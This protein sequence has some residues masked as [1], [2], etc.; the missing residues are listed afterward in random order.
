M[1]VRSQGTSPAPATAKPAGRLLY[2]D[3]IRIFLTILVILHHLMVIYAG[4]GGWIYLEGRED[5]FTRL[6]GSWFCGS[7]QA[8]FMGLFLL[9]SAYFVPGS[10][11]RKGPGKFLVDRLVRLGI[12]L[13]F[14]S[15]VLRPLLIYLGLRDE[16]GVSFWA[17]YTHGYFRDYGLI[18][19]GP[20]WFIETLLIFSALYVVWR[21]V[22]R[23]A[24]PA[25]AA[26]SRFPRSRTIALFALLL[27]LASFLVRLQFP[28]NSRFAP[29]NL[30][31]ANLPQ[32]IAL[33]ILGLLAYRRRWLSTLSDATGKLWLGIG[34]L[35][36]A[37]NGPVQLL[38]G[39]AAPTAPAPAGEVLMSLV[40]AEWEAFVCVGMC[41][42]LV[43]FFRRHL[44]RQG[45]LARELSRT[46]YTA[47]L[48]HEPVVTFAALFAAGVMIYPLLK[49]LL[50][51]L[52]LV[53]VCFALSSLI[54]RIPYADRVL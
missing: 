1:G 6:I 52:V 30:Q 17:W 13:A 8:Y 15:W 50:A 3:N 42:G 45:P 21:L 54:R 25:P 53:P 4:S 38:M 44:D 32:Y 51:G 20:L 27:G 5:R 7:N 28:V 10:Y 24:A 29:L 41:I 46:A 19:G 47:Y 11:D 9:V 39:A 43:Y 23:P 14:Y 40:A 2:V 36:I 22:V 33:F 12:P 26:E 34:L 48:I 49:F 35:L 37:L 16:L 18:G 31:L